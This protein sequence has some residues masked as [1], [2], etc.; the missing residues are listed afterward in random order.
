M[1][2]AVYLDVVDDPLA[3][4]LYLGDSEI[5]GRLARGGRRLAR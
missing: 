3:C 5:L 2:R 1:M 4:A